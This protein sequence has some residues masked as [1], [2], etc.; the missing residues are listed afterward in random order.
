[1]DAN[2]TR[3]HLLLGRADWVGSRLPAGLAW[4]EAR[5]GVGLAPLPFVFPARAGEAPLSPDARAGAARDRFGNWYWV[6]DDGRSIRVR[7]PRDR[8]SRTFWPLA[9]T[10]PECDASAEA[11]SFLPA[12]PPVPAEPATLQGLAVTRDHYLVAGMP[13]RPGGLLIHDLAAGGEPVHLPW[14][15]DMEF[16]PWDVV[17]A[18]DGGLWILERE[19][20]RLWRLDWLFRV[21]APGPVEPSAPPVHDFEPVEEASPPGDAVPWNE[22]IQPLHVNPA[23]AVSASAVVQPVAAESLP[24]GSVLV[25]GREAGGPV[26]HRYTLAG[27]AGRYRV[28]PLVADHPQVVSMLPRAHDVAFID[29]GG[30]A[31][32]LGGRLFLMAPGGNQS[33]AFNV[34]GDAGSPDLSFSETFY[35]MRRAGGRG[36]VAAGGEVHYQSGDRWVALLE[37]PRPRFRSQAVHQLPPAR[38][39]GGAGDDEGV[40]AFD[41]R[42][43]GCT[44]HRLFLDGCI[45]PGSAVRVESR[46]ADTRAGLAA[47]AWQ[48]EP[49]PYLRAGGAELPWPAHALRTGNG[50]G[51]GTWELLFQQAR[52][53]YLQLRITL[54][55]NG[56]ETPLL[57]A[58]RIHYPRFSYLREYLPAVWRENAESAS[59]TDRFL[60]N[61]EGTLTGIEDRIAAT[62]VLFD[63]ASVPAGFLEWL[64]G[65]VSVSLDPSWDE[66]R[67]RLFIANAVRMFARR[68]T[69]GGLLRSL[70]LALESCT[71]PQLFDDNAPL[72]PF[73][74][75]VVEEFQVRR[76]G[77]TPLLATGGSVRPAD[78]TSVASAWTPA[79][80]AAPLHR[81]WR[82]W[83]ES[84]HGSVAA[85]NEAWGTNHSSLDSPSIV[86]S[87]LP[88]AG[89]EGADWRQFITR[90]LGFTYAEATQADVGAWRDLL[91]RRY[92]NVEDLNRAWQL[93]GTARHASLDTVP[94]PVALP[95][96]GAALTDWITFASVVL[97]MRRAAHR[98]TVLV[99][100][101]LEDPP[102]V[103][104]AR[105][106][107][108]ERVALLEKPAHTVVR[109]RLVWAAFQVGSARLGADTLLGRGSRFAAAVIGAAELGGS[110]LGWTE[111]WN[112]TGR[113]VVGRDA[114]NRPLLEGACS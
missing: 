104:R 59:F 94:L 68:G 111:P 3:F 48:E 32:E 17:A 11:G 54:R 38:T 13:G 114:A 76:D 29:D 109:T 69:P 21:R 45:P 92:T 78:A 15:D 107:L 28:A 20:A 99:P 4:H 56:R 113:R 96:G 95:A 50:A 87:P 24:D 110:H 46:A 97:P 39:A 10:G 1:M 27:A 73:S 8:A 58:A 70:R 102:A 16:A 53:R 66:Q 98:F 81:R 37:Q 60:A 101:Q 18:P 51:A 55:G 90:G 19:P 83:L 7:S 89:R 25:L 82:S 12:E 61:V 14:S 65:W 5:H 6:A 86:L 108:A 88:P 106:A 22:C 42:E 35:P 40:P 34:R 64:G 80:G 79:L 112:A 47:E 62:Q 103:Q 63:P 52:G 91:V 26:L 36:L 41:G 72:P 105:R 23:H 67:Q 100:V 77:G 85:L 33:F 43:P 71:D 44:W 49:A 93:H 31:G 74:V 9:A 57:T 84:A 2:G 30:N 75:R